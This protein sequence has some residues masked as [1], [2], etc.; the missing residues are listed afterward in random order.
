MFTRTRILLVGIGGTG[1]E[2]VV[3]A[4]M[5]FLQDTGSVPPSVRLLHIDTAPPKPRGNVSLD[6][7]ETVLLCLRDPSE[8]L[9]DPDNSHLRAWFPEKLKVGTVMN[10]AAQIRALGRLALHAQPHYVRKQL[11][12]TIGRLTD[13]GRLRELGKGESIDEQGAIEVYILASVCGGTGSGL[14]VDVAQ[15]IKDQLRNA[16]SVHICGVFLLPGPFRQLAGTA[17]VKSNSYATLKELDYLAAP[18]AP[19]EFSFGAGEGRAL[20]ASPFNLIYLVDSVSEHFDTTTDVSHLAR[21][22]ASLPYLMSTPSVGPHVREV[23]RNLIPQLETKPLVHGKRATYASFG[24]AT[25]EIP[26]ASIAAA[27]AQFET[28]LLGQLLANSGDVPGLGDLGVEDGLAKCRSGHLPEGLMLFLPTDFAHPRMGIGKLEEGYAE[29]VEG[30][31]AFGRKLAEPHLTSLRSSGAKAVRDLLLYVSSHAGR[32]P[33]ATREC[34]RLAA[35]LKERQAA[36]RAP[37][38]TAA[39][40]ENA[41]MEAWTLCKKAYESRRSRPRRRAALD[42]QGVVNQSVLPARLARAINDE[43]ADALGYLADQVRELEQ[44]L[45]SARRNLADDLDRLSKL[46]PAVESPPSSFTGHRDAGAVRPRTDAASFLGQLKDPVAWFS[47]PGIEVQAEVTA[48]AER[49]CEPAFAAGGRSSATQLLLQDL[50]ASMKELKRFSDPLWSYNAD[51]IPRE[52]QSGIQLIEVLGVDRLSG[53][54]NSI[55]SQYPGLGIVET[56]WGNRVVHLQIRAGVP[57]FA[58]SSMND[59]WHDYSRN[60]SGHMRAQFHADGRWA[61]WPELLPHAFDG[62]VIESLALGLAAS[63]VVHSA[64]GLEITSDAT[65]RKLLGETFAAAYRTLSNDR[66]QA[67]A[68]AIASKQ[69]RSDAPS[70]SAAEEEMWRLLSRDHL[71]ASDRSLVEAL[72]QYLEQM[73]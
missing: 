52:H 11:I 15:L 14:I 71:P 61:N 35:Y 53:S 44:W 73:S 34:S 3:Q 6:A 36:L 8:A 19:V 51:K 69:V 5:L 4:K 37:G 45:E 10:G 31:E 24:F 64:C 32:I 17:R 54:V 43:A 21:Q 41:R 46:N 55:S 72:M 12:D 23:L 42:W 40:A 57:L 28:E 66:A 49:E 50:N 59:L 33:S 13:R 48:F 16:P 63:V 47:G 67:R 65:G 9:S 20:L 62:A 27:K 2:T 7:L 29:A 39:D 30:V 70:V 60:P 38:R 58:L 1:L 25:L 68:I 56:G 22:M 26:R 18:H